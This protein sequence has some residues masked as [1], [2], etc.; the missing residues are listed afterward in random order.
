[1]SF[2]APICFQQLASN[3]TKQ[4]ALKRATAGQQIIHGIGGDILNLEKTK[5]LE[6]E[7]IRLADCKNNLMYKL[8]FKRDCG[9][10]NISKICKA[11]ARYQRRQSIVSENQEHFKPV[12]DVPLTV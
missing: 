2:S 11:I 3:L 6:A 10:K 7:Q 5:Y 12:G 8:H 1:M 4:F 9:S